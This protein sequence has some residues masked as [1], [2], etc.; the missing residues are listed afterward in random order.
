MVFC[1]YSSILSAMLSEPTVKLATHNDN[2]AIV[3][4]SR[5]KSANALNSQMALELK[6]IFLGLTDNIRA[7]IL[8]GE[9]NRAFCAGADLKERDGMS[10]ESWQKQHLLFRQ[11]IKSIMDCKIPVIAAV[12]GAAYGGGLEL[13]LACDFI[14]AAETACFALP[15]VTLGIMPGMGGTQN[16]P[17]TMGLR[18]GKE[19]LFTG[20]SFSTT[21]AYDWG[22]VNKLCKAESL[23]DDVLACAKSIAGNA[24]LSIV[25][26]KHAADNI[27]L[28]ISEALVKESEQYKKL[29]PTTDRHEGIT[30]FNKKRPPVFTGK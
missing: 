30:A 9:G 27:H 11:T 22:M 28:P 26:I 29:L 10:E 18:R 4:L 13:A 23:T 25:A 19:L 8:T 15:E 14:Y 1:E 5:T 12:N 16:L 2:I 24:P 6:D 3:T 17:R 7:V 20:K 21:E